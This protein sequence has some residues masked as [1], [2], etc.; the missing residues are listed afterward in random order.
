[1]NNKRLLIF[2]VVAVAGL[3]VVAL[4][5]LPYANLDF[6]SAQYEASSYGGPKAGPGIPFGDTGHGDATNAVVPNPGNPQDGLPDRASRAVLYDAPNGNVIG[7]DSGEAPITG[8]DATGNWCRIWT[9]GE[10]A[11]WVPC[12]GFNPNV[13][14]GE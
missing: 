7:T 8:F 13:I 1:M 14:T 3:A 2:A 5:G 6:A 9:G 11:A 12:P 4:A 10:A